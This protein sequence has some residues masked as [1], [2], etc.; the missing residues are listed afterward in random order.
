MLANY[1]DLPVAAGVDHAPAAKTAKID[2]EQMRP[3]SRTALSALV[4]LAALAAIS[5]VHAKPITS[6][7]KKRIQVINGRPAISSTQKKDAEYR[8][9]RALRERESRDGASGCLWRSTSTPMGHQHKRKQGAD[10]AQISQRAHVQT[11]R[12][13]IA[14]STPA[15]HVA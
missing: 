4:K 1:G 7:T 5:E 14:T 8:Q 13:E 2:P 10:V 11:G 9:D 6:H 12:P 3:T 15:N